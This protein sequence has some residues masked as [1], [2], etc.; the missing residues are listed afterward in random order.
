MTSQIRS[1]FLGVA[2]GL[3]MPLFGATQVSA[4]DAYHD[5]WSQNVTIGCFGDRGFGDLIRIIAT[6]VVNEQQVY[7]NDSL[8]ASNGMCDVVGSQ[9]R[10]T[11]DSAEANAG[12]V[13]GWNQV[14]LVSWLVIPR[15][16]GKGKWLVRFER[17]GYPRQVVGTKTLGDDRAWRPS[18]IYDYA[19]WRL[20]EYC[21]GQMR[22]QT[23]PQG[24]IRGLNPQ[25]IPFG[26]FCDLPFRIQ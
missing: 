19:K 26:S 1:V 22:E 24:T 11:N 9:R 7:N 8:W 20:P 2:L 12:G 21:E 18:R 14:G 10:F 23:G 15:S 5:S 6:E 25:R 17:I 16:D 3:L 13:W 4:Q